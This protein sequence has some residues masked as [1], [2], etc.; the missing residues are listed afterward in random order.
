MVE[1]VRN[2]P[3]RF[4]SR[5]ARLS[6]DAYPGAYYGVSSVD[7]SLSPD[8]PVARVGGQASEPVVLPDSAMGSVSSPSVGSGGADGEGAANGNQLTPAI[9]REVVR[10][11]LRELGYDDRHLTTMREMVVYTQGRSGI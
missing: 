5:G 6:T 7:I 11:F 2:V 9:R 3:S 8:V 10:D 4:Y 1:H